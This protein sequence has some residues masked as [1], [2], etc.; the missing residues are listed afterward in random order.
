MLDPL[1][2]GARDL[3]ARVGDCVDRDRAPAS[4][5]M[6]GT[7]PRERGLPD[8]HAVAPRTGA[9]RRVDDEVAAAGTDRVDDGLA[10]LERAD[11]ESG[12]LSAARAAGR[13]QPEAERRERLARPARPVLV[14]VAH[15]EKRGSARSG[16][17]ARG[18]LRLR[19]GSRQ[20]GGARH[21]FA[22]RAHLGTERRVGAR[23]ARNGSTAA[24]T[25]PA[26]RR[27]SGRSSSASEHRPRAG[28]R[29]RRD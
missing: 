25:S 13:E 26:G 8:Q 5:V 7:R 20:V 15:G 6:Q 10:L 11:V 9:L 23:E 24:L 27:S 29:R 2:K 18:A 1:L 19:E 3:L 14:G 22:R 21:H 12:R 17:A 4:V 28:R 16:A